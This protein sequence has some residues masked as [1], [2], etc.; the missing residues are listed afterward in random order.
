MIISGN[1]HEDK[2]GTVRFINDFQFEGVKRFYS[3]NHSSTEIIRAWQGHKVETK[4]FFV[5]KGSFLFNWIKLDNWE[6]PSRELVIQSKLLADSKSEIL[7][8]EG[9]H[10]TGL[11]AT[12]PDS[13]LIVFS[14]K[15]LEESKE[16][17]YRFHLDYWQFQNPS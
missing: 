1:K 7:M 15:T 12:K 5:A 9:G 4:W 11:K 10:V 8:I 6:T 2:R 17:D 16:D 3:I 14:D 13:V